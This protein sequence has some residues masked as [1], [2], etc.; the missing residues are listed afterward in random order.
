MGSFLTIYEP[1]DFS[2]V[3]IP[4]SQNDNEI[5]SQNGTQLP[6]Y[7]IS[8]KRDLKLLEKPDHFSSYLN[9]V[10]DVDRSRTTSTSSYLRSPVDDYDDLFSTKFTDDNETAFSEAMSDLD[11]SVN[12][13]DEEM[14]PRLKICCQNTTS[15]VINNKECNFSGTCTDDDYISS[16]M[17]VPGTLQKCNEEKKLNSPMNDDYIFS[18]ICRMEESINDSVMSSKAQSSDI[19]SGH[20]EQWNDDE[21]GTPLSVEPTEQS[22]SNGYV[23]RDVYSPGN[24]TCNIE[25]FIETS[26][27]SQHYEDNR[28]RCDQV[29]AISSI[30]CISPDVCLQESD[31]TLANTN[32]SSDTGYISS[33]ISHEILD[34]N[35]STEVAMPV[36]RTPISDTGYISSSFTSHD[37]NQPTTFHES[38]DNINSTA[39][40][41]SGYLTSTTYKTTNYDE[42]TEFQLPVT[43]DACYNHYVTNKDLATNSVID[44][45]YIQPDQQSSVKDIIPTYNSDYF[46]LTETNLQVL[47]ENQDNDVT[48]D[49]SHRTITAANDGYIY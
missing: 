14:D 5:E 18:D 7:S 45:G 30:G 34:Q 23:S 2:L 40:S 33:S 3:K 42:S 37:Q 17:S 26:F 38:Y 10:T 41:D 21:K 46:S 44:N 48:K 35:Q 28:I 1:V 27:G 19:T 25:M 9:A 29:D 4:L 49:I 47:S 32:M 11:G 6:S 12:M 43:S 16:G 24:V 39:T 15:K 31:K 8:V 36:Y 22:N 20:M 13:C